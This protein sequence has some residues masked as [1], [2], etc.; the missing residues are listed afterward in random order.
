MGPVLL[1]IKCSSISCVKLCLPLQSKFIFP[2]MTEGPNL[3]W[4]SLHNF[5]KVY[6]LIGWDVKLCIHLFQTFF[7][8]ILQITIQYQF[9]FI[10]GICICTSIP[11]NNNRTYIFFWYKWCITGLVLTKVLLGFWYKPSFFFYASHH[12]FF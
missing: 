5:S 6:S 7:P 4:D 11:S 10:V 9:I 3:T 8:V 1:L 2:I 12:F